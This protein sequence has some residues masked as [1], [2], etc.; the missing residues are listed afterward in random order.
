MIARAACALGMLLAAAG[1]ACAADAPAGSAAAPNSAIVYGD[2]WA[3]IVAV[4]A[5]WESDCCRRAPERGVNLLVYPHGWDG[6]S[7][8]RVMSLTVWTKSRPT[9]DADWDA[10]AKDYLEHFPGVAAQPFPV[11]LAARRCRSAVYTGSDSLREYVVFCDAGQ[12]LNFRFAWSMRTEG[13]P[14]DRAQL[15]N[16]FRAVVA[17][18]LPMAA[19]IERRAE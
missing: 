2:G 11:S 8:D 14:A 18:T 1:V 5:G 13:E 9:L 19:T 12:D 17:Q 6:K 15:E 3:E 16:L 7:D 10:D 4:P